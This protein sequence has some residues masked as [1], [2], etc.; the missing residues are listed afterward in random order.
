MMQLFCGALSVHG[1]LRILPPTNPPTTVTFLVTRSLRTI[2]CC[3]S[4]N[5]P[6]W[7][8]LR[9]V[10]KFNWNFSLVGHQ[11]LPHLLCSP[12]NSL[13]L[14]CDTCPF[15]PLPQHLFFPQPWSPCQIFSL[16]SHSHLYIQ[17]G[18]HFEPRYKYERNIY[19]FLSLD[20]LA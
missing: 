11:E 14:L 3:H 13:L 4:T 12:H 1:A 8:A 5:F 7:A 6:L 19:C 9:L 16:C 18:I 15:G 2:S 10:V 17:T 20:H